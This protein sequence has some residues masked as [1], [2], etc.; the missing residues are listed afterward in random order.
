M[1]ITDS[2]TEPNLIDFQVARMEAVHRLG[3]K[4]IVGYKL[5]ESLD[6]RCIHAVIISPG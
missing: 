1:A 3:G 6:V 4:I 2:L 5:W